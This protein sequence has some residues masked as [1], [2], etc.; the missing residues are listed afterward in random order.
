[1]A[2]LG[3]YVWR[4]PYLLLGLTI[5][6]WSGNSII[7]RAVRDDIPPLTLAALRWIGATAI[8]L[9]F[10]VGPG[11]RDWPVLRDHWQI[12]LVLGLS[13]VAAFNTLLYLG[14]GRTTA[15][16]ALLIQ[17]STPPFILL[18]AWMLEGQRT[19]V[20]RL[21][22]TALSM[23]GVMIVVT[24][25]QV[26]T[27]LHLRLNVGDIFV[28]IA[29]VLWAVYTVLLPRRPDLHP[30]SFLCATFVVGVAVVT[31]LAAWELSHGARIVWTPMA[32]GAAFYVALF[33]S[34]IAY[35][36]YTRG[37]SLVGGAVAGQFIN[38]MP[39]VG[40]LLAVLALGEPLAAYHL[41]GMATILLGIIWFTRTQ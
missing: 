2:A 7:G 32:I 12:I 29:S 9:P 19:S 16:N 11:R 40:A 26:E 28:L 8:L 23:A 41:V 34:V 10:A 1:M 13:G 31:P 20:A 6:F 39:L 18:I 27:L 14:L 4:Q 17:A 30:L 21:V 24:Q 3:A 33:P 36:F 37:V 5:L 25:G 15:S 35:V 22:G 38:A